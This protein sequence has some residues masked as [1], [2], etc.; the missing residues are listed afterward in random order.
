MQRS[1]STII[2]IGVYALL[3]GLILFTS[4]DKEDQSTNQVPLTEEDKLWKEAQKANKEPEKT[5]PEQLDFLKDSITRYETL[6]YES[7]EAKL[8]GTL[9]LIEEVEQSIKQY[10]AALLSQVKATYK[11]ARAALY[12]KDNLADPNVMDTYDAKILAMI[13]AVKKFKEQTAEFD[14]HQ[15][16]VLIYND[17]LTADNKDLL[18]RSRY[19]M[20]VSDFNRLLEDKEDEID[21][22]DYQY[23]RLKPYPFY[24]GEDPQTTL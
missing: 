15:R 3:F 16:A 17:I 10:D 8:N 9:L 12:T 21:D 2:R 6:A 22:L 24:W 1:Y 13:N 19:N 23:R 11:E 5:L 4:C 14:R 20:N 18:L 7:E